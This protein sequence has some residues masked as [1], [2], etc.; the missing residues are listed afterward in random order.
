MKE[1]NKIRF[2]AT[3][4][5]NLQGLR[6]VPIGV[7]ILL[8]GLLAN[9][10]WAKGAVGASLWANGI[11]GAAK[12]I[13]ILGVLLVSTVVSLFI[14]DKYYFHY[15]GHIQRT[16][17]SSRFEW[18]IQIVGSI[19]LLIAFWIDITFRLP[20]SCIGLVFA[21]VLIVEYIRLTWL[22]G[23][24]F[25]IYYPL[26][27]ILTAIV[28]ILPLFGIPQWWLA[29]GLVNELVGIEMVVGVFCIFGG[30]WGHLFLL[31]ALSP[32]LEVNNDHT[33]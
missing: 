5:I 33:I 15:F 14:I 30:V 27:A 8:V 22:V 29:V 23:G 4:F 1:S 21:T 26:G 3:N 2:I 10:M 17:Q 25:L 18:I 9:S 19:F 12:Y 20:V 7:F 28:S 32:R 31:R 11:A 24:R 13:I 16:P 6:N